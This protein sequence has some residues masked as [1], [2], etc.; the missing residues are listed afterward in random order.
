MLACGAI[1]GIGGYRMA[2][3][4]QVKTQLNR[5][6][7]SVWWAFCLMLLFLFCSPPTHS[8]WLAWIAIFCAAY[9][10]TFFASGHILKWMPMKINGLLWWAGG[11]AIRLLDGGAALAVFA[12]LALAGEVGFGL[13]T[14]AHER[15][16]LRSES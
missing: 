4:Q 8:S 5:A 16:A 6:I 13:Y 14:M 15:K 1:M 2:K 7:S 11:I 10:A 9:G 12:V 3:K